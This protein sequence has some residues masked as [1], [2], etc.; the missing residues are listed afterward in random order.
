MQHQR[1]GKKNFESNHP[2]QHYISFVA[3]S[4]TIFCNI[5]KSS[6]AKFGTFN[7][8][9]GEEP[10]SG[11]ASPAGRERRRSCPSISGGRGAEEGAARGEQQ[12]LGGEEQLCSGEMPWSWA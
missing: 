12:K 5:R 10:C 4:Q 9:G 11:Q 1:G 8:E 3:T 7:T 6:I 2:W